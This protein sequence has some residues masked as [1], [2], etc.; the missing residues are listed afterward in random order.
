MN[1][2]KDFIGAGADIKIDPETIKRMVNDKLNTDL[3]ER[4]SYMKYKVF[5][6][7]AMAAALTAAFSLT[8]F[9]VFFLE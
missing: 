4:R 3:L 7:A 5:K 9:A 8:A 6:T 2:R 1:R